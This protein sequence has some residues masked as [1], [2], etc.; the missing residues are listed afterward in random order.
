MTALDFERLP[1]S[2]LAELVELLH[3]AEA[4]GSWPWQVLLVIGRLLGKKSGGERVIG[5]LSM[6]TRVW[7]QA[8]ELEVKQWG[9][10]SAPE[11]DAAVPG[12]SALHEALGRALDEEAHA[13]LGFAYA[14]A[15]LDFKSF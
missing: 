15:M 10:A 1:D 13:A 5:L 7:S 14:H 8:R 9:A 2:G 6:L 11:W 4:C 12:N 3:A